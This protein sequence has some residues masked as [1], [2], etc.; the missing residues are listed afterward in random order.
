M[1]LFSDPQQ[2]IAEISKADRKLGKAMRRLG[3]FELD[4]TS[5]RNP[6]QHLARAIIYHQ[7]SGKAAGTIFSRV[8]DLF[9]RKHFKPQIVLDVPEE[10]LR[11][12]GLSRNKL[13]AIR[14]LAVKTL[15]GTV[16]TL[17]KLKSMADAEIIERLV[18]V[19]GIGPWTVE[20]LL[21]F[22]LG[23]PDVLPNTDLSI[24]K[25]YRTLE[26]REEMPTPKE[27]RTLT[28]HWRPLR[29]VASCYLYR[30]ADKEGAG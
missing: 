13:A 5:M 1:P 30:L 9:P 19:R 20:M 26:G 18:Q 21:I 27:L 11:G 22:R 3:S 10:G 29:S 16:P 24:R 8:K 4:A 23:R 15:D 14:D 6:F 28:E 12:A 17:V 7:L 2:A 25:G